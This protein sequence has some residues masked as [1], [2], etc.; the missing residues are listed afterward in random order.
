MKGDLGVIWAMVAGAGASGSHRDRMEH[1]YR[2]Q[3]GAYDRFRDRFLHG[4]R[5][6]V[7]RLP[8]GPGA[9]IAELGGGTGRNL[10]FFGERLRTFS[11]ATVVDLCPPLLEVA[12]ARAARLGWTNVDV[13]EGDATTWRPAD[14]IPLDGVFFSYS[15]TMIPD[16]F[17]AIDNANA[18]L[19]PGGVLGA[20]DFHISRKHPGAGG[21]RHRPLA[22]AFWR[23][24][25]AHD[26]VFVSPDHLPYL[27]SRTD[28]VLREERLGKVPYLPLLRAPYY[29]FIGRKPKGSR[30]SEGVW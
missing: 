25:F 9:R 26:D 29:V 12:R 10:E 20:V 19:A 16:W 14:G 2:R 3:A 24:W 7:E 8:L 17:L 13:A 18:M 6:L 11:R 30:E 28:A 21:A 27:E 15:L 5:E 22:R 4:R 1:L 23:W